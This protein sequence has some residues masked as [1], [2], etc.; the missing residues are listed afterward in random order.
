V[1]KWAQRKRSC[2]VWKCDCAAHD[3]QLLMSPDD[4]ERHKRVDAE[5]EP[6]TAPKEI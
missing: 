5:L 6:V 1:P 4:L 3:D 2:E